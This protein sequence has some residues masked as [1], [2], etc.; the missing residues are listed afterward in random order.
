MFDPLSQNER[1]VIMLTDGEPNSGNN[2]NNNQ[3]P[4]TNGSTT[5]ADLDN[6]GVNMTIV[7]IGDNIDFN[8]LQCLLDDPSDFIEGDFTNTELVTEDIYIF[9]D[10]DGDLVDDCV[11]G[12][13]L[14]GDG[15]YS[16]NGDPDD[17]NV[18]T[19]PNACEICD[20]DDND[21]DMLVDEGFPDTDG[22]GIADCVDNC[23]DFASTDQTDSDGDGVGD[24]CDACPND[25]MGT[26]D[27]DGDGVCDYQD[28]CP[29]SINPQQDDED[30]DGVGDVCDACPNAPGFVD[31]DGDGVCDSSDDD[32]DNDGVADVNDIDPL[33]PF[34]C[35]DSDGDT[36]DDCNVGNDGF[37][38]LADIDNLNDGLDTDGDGACDAG[39]PDDDNDGVVDANDPEPLN[40]FVCGDSDGDTCDDC[41]VGNDGFGPLADIDN[42]NDGLDTDGDGI[43]DAGDDD[44]DNDG[45]LDVDDACPLI[46]NFSAPAGEYFDE[47]TCSFTICPP[48]SYCPGGTTEAIPC[49]LGRVNSEEGA[50]E[51]IPCE[52]GFYS[53]VLGALVC[54]PCVAGKYQDEI[55]ASE[56]KTCLAGTFQ[57]EMAA[58]E[59]KDCPAGKF[60]GQD[61]AIACTDCPKGK[62]NPIAG[63]S[64]CLNCD[65]GEYQDEVGQTTCKACEPGNYSNIQG[66]AECIPCAA[67]SSQSN[68]GS[69]SCDECEPLSFTDTE[70]SEFCSDC[71]MGT[72]NSGFGNTGCI[73]CT[74]SITC[75]DD[76]V[77]DTD[78]GVCTASNLDLGNAITDNTCGNL[79]VGNNA[80]EPYQLG[81][82]EVLWTATDVIGENANCIQRVIVNDNEAPMA[83]CQNLTIALDGSGSASITPEQVDNLS[84][85]NCSIAELSLDNSSFDCSNIGLN[86]VELTVA[87]NA[88]NLVVGTTDGLIG[89]WTFEPGIETVDLTGNWQDLQTFGG[90]TITNGYLDVTGFS[91]F[92]RVQ[93]YSGPVIRSKTLVSWVSLDNL[94]IQS[95][96][97]LT[98]DRITVDNF[99]AIVYAERQANRWMNGSSSFSRTQDA[100]PG[101]AEMNANELV[102]MAI[103]YEDLNN[104]N[105]RIT[106]YRNGVQIGQYDDGPIGTWVAGDAEM[107]M[108]KRHGSGTNG[109]GQL[110]AKINEARLYGRTLSS[111]EVLDLYNQGLTIENANTSSCTAQVTVL[112]NT[113][114][115]A[116]CHDLTIDLQN[117][118]PISL[119]T[120]EIAFMISGTSDNCSFDTAYSGPASFDCDNRGESIQVEFTFTDPA[121]NSSSCTPNVNIIDSQSVC[122]DPPTAVCQD[123]TVETGDNCDASV[124]AA[125]IDNG[126]S[127]PDGDILTYSLDNSGPFGVGQHVVTLSVSD[128][129]YT[130]DCQ[131]TVT[132]EDNTF[133]SIDTEASDETVECG[134]GNMDALNDWLDSHG[135]AAASDACGVEWSNDFAGLSDLCG[136]TG[137]ATVT[138][139]ATDPSGNASQTIASFSI[140]DTTAPT[141]SGCPAGQSVC[142]DQDLTTGTGAVVNWT[143]PTASD[144]CGS[145]ILVASHNPGDVF[146]VGVT[147]VTYTAT[148][149]CELTSQCSFDIEVFGL[150]DAAISEAALSAYCQ[151]N[152]KTLTASQTAGAGTVSYQWSTGDATAD[153]YVTE[154][155]TYTL[156]ITDENSCTR[157]LSY[158]VDIVAEDLLSSYTLL[159][160]DDV[161]LHGNNEVLNG[162]VGVY[163]DKGKVKVHDESFVVGPTTF[164]LSTDI[165]VKD[166]S[167]VDTEIDNYLTLELPPFECNP[168]KDGEDVKV[169]KN[170]SMVLNGQV[171]GK[172]EVKE[173][174]TLEFTASDI[175]IED[176]KTKDGATI[177]FSGCSFVRLEKNL[178]IYKNVQFN[179]Y[180]EQVQLYVDGNVEIKEGAL[181]NAN[182]DARGHNINAK[183]KSNNPTYVNGRIIGKKIH[184]DKYVI[185]DWG[186]GCESD[187]SPG[188]A[189]YI[190]ACECKG[191]MIQL[192]VEYS[193]GAGA[194]ISTNSGQ[195][196]DNGDGTY[197]VSNCADKLDKKLKLDDGS[198]DVEIHTSCSQDILGET[199]DGLYT[200]LSHTDKDGNQSTVDNCP[201]GVSGILVNNDERPD[202]NPELRDG[203]AGSLIG[204]QSNAMSPTLEEGGLRI[205]PNPATQLFF[206]ELQSTIARAET[207]KLYDTRGALVLE[208]DHMLKEGINRFEVDASELSGGLYIVRVGDFEMKRL[209]VVK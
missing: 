94:N 132:V 205:Y 49:P 120:S 9:V 46:D 190:Q 14:D 83:N 99:D 4:C 124:S 43:C 17:T 90:A 157:E 85:D 47:L 97:A 165:D 36:C 112:D 98:I 39:D 28:N 141:I 106:L 41:N 177:I 31:T 179:P 161:H 51:C 201:N 189:P 169:E 199:F 84:S 102:M 89:H 154:S 30:M 180:G 91:D 115:E 204:F 37:G 135:G 142:A 5:A 55:G 13:D 75:P 155:G 38:P 64:E 150:P 166:D 145:P 15:W 137:S 58:T 162:G 1:Y 45:I 52:K 163:D 24:A 143:V 196:T 63:Q 87:D 188:E 175:F 67:G 117:R 86:T 128:A 73:T 118:L 40:P 44:D 21:G 136:A 148:D 26:L 207:I 203:N 114:P 16:L 11:Q 61:G 32:D 206:V 48:G 95:G 6:L 116:V 70:G 185:W 62:Y 209:M 92:A 173:G 68:F 113:A 71:P 172:V 57:N 53:P 168:F 2:S 50:I 25:P 10:E 202:A 79:N 7:G 108:G 18:N 96:S 192:V 125:M 123:V 35:G 133:P 105:V 195:I 54:L 88:S 193:G 130:D 144:N 82:T 134:A 194:A 176:L 181:V 93:G 126:S 23:P 42:L 22:D 178:D 122:N 56:C 197:T 111:T 72:W 156:L 191:G 80:N 164:V 77:V 74:V 131:A 140:V 34:I 151:G 170:Q 101:F 60:S 19:N 183:G 127:D 167:E 78:V 107:W 182:I 100:V 8:T 152:G 65:A 158:T 138:F 139:T 121:G 81:I 110:D 3:D 20:G 69:T 184:G 187:C 27:S 146:N 208:K 103:S 153:T 29:N 200:V 66:A 186:T 147:T 171:Y 198:G 119:S 159:A 59:C 33:N 104:N 174:A 109:P 12:V 129:E 160:E 149:E 76:V